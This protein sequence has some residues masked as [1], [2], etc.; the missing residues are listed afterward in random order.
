MPEVLREC[1]VQH[2]AFGI[3]DYEVEEYLLS[4]GIWFFLETSSSDYHSGEYRL[5]CTM[6]RISEGG[7]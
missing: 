3:E 7:T 5:Y 2:S 1:V 4:Q 6:L